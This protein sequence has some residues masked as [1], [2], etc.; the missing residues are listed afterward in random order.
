MMIWCCCVEGIQKNSL[1][2]LKYL[3]ERLGLLLN[4]TKTKTVNAWVESFDFLGFEIRMNRSSR[5]GV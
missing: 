4:E 1:S 2:M 3:L 5:S